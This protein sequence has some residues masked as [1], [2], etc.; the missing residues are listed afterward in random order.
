MLFSCYYYFRRVH[1]SK[2]AYDNLNGAFEVEPGNG[3]ERD[4]FLAENSIETFL[5]VG[6]AK[7]ANNHGAHGAAASNNDSNNEA[8]PSKR[9]QRWSIKYR[10]AA[11]NESKTNGVQH[12]LKTLSEDESNEGDH[13][14]KPEIPFGNVMTS[15]KKLFEE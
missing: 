4:I 13:E 11:A 2:A 10:E 14:W 9:H 3:G 7:P 1:I 12:L 8:A 6:K 5:I 15:N